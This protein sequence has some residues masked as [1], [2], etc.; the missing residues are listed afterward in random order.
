MRQRTAIDRYESTGRTTR[1]RLR[2]ARD[3]PTVE[4]GKH[5]GMACDKPNERESSPCRQT[6]AYQVCG[7]RDNKQC[8]LTSVHV[9]SYQNT[10]KI[11]FRKSIIT[12]AHYVRPTYGYVTALDKNAKNVNSLYREVAIGNVDNPF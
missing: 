8:L 2:S 11:S 3:W 10:E 5:W 1:R 4:C 12:C 9:V 6:C 7:H